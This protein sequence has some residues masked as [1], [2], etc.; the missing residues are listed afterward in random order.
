MFESKYVESLT[1]SIEK[2]ISINNEDRLEMGKKSRKHVEK[3]F[4]KKIVIKEY[5]DAVRKYIK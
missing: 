3:N 5:L 4:D 1:E 2:I